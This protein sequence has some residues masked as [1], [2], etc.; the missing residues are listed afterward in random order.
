MQDQGS[1]STAQGA[2]LAKQGDR[3][4][5]VAFKIDPAV[6]ATIDAMARC[7]K[8][9]RPDVLRR[10]LSLGVSKATEDAFDKVRANLAASDFV[11]SASYAT[12]AS[13]ATSV[14]YAT[15]ANPAI[16]TGY[17]TPTGYTTPASHV[18]PTNLATPTEG[19]AVEATTKT[20][21]SAVGAAPKTIAET[22]TD[23]TTET[24]MLLDHDSLVLVDALSRAGLGS[25]SDVAR[26]AI[27][28]GLRCEGYGGDDA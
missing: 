3:P 28:K 5:T 9:T 24:T 25:R 1:G 23:V 26:L 10:L 13:Y 8:R 22:A 12:P 16:S 4:I 15:S 2:R 17:A 20:E 21:G 27:E 7:V 18:T 14:S 19:G 11:A 6:L